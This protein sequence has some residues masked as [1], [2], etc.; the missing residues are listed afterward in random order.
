M[1][2]RLQR[3]GEAN[4]RA[5]LT[6]EDIDE[7]WHA[8]RQRD[9]LRAEAK[10]LREEARRLDKAAMALSN[11]ALARTRDVSETAIRNIITRHMWL[12]ITPK[13]NLPSL[14]GPAMV[15]ASSGSRLAD[16]GK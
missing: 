16:S 6:N 5:K 15:S 4:G 10:R 8:V 2:V 14:T 13:G 3:L 12:H 1:K 9:K 11:A 7:I